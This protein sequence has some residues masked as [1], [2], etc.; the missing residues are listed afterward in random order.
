MGWGL[1]LTFLQWGPQ[2]KLHRRLFQT[3]FSQTAVKAFR[4]IQLAEARKCVRSL[5]ASPSD[6][7]DLTLLLTT[8]VIFRIA[9]GQAVSTT[10]SPYCALSAAANEATSNGGIAGSSLVDVFPPARWLPGWMVPSPSLRHARRSRPAIRAIR[11]VPWQANL[12]DIERGV[13]SPSFMKTH[14]ERHRA[15]AADAG[16]RRSDMTEADVKGATSAVFI[17]G[18]N[19]TWSTVQSVL[20][21]LTKYPALQRRVREEIDGVVVGEGRLPDFEDRARLPYLEKFVNE[22]QRVLPMNPLN[23]P[24]MSIEDDVYRGMFIPRG[25]VVFSNTTAMN[26]DAATY[27]RPEAFDPDRYDRGEPYPVGNFGFGRRK[28]P[29]NFL[30]MATVYIFLATLLATF[31]LEKAL[32]PD[33]EEI[34]PEIGG[35]FGLGG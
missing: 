11:E 31:E 9:F 5:V 15:D 3:T 1:T 35:S 27:A 29:G 14:L 6:W 30:A 20:L 4:P 18:G 32:G 12:R 8:S 7:K 25:S 34:E 10:A 21:L 28:C 19:S 17:A 16:G 13:A 24:H 33:G 2:F 26:N 23:I 22:V